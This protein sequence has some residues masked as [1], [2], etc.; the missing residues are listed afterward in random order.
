[1][2][3]SQEGTR[4]SNGIPDVLVY[5]SFGASPSELAIMG[6][7]L[8]DITLSSLVKPGAFSVP[9]SSQCRSTEVVPW[10]YAILA[11]QFAGCLKKM[12]LE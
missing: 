11:T 4:G 10:G 1:M 3:L 9:V 6:V 2:T 12:L 7:P 5:T 8:H